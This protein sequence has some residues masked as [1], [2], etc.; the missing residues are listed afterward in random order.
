M[1]LDCKKDGIDHINIYSKARTAL[2]LFLSNF[3][4]VDLE[5]DY[6][7]FQS[8]EAFWYWLS[9]PEEHPRREELR[10]LAGWPA[11]KLGR[12]VRGIDYDADKDPAFQNQI[13]KVLIYKIDNS[14]FRREFALSTLPFQ[15]Y[16]V[17]SGK[18]SEP[19]SGK[20]QIEFFEEYRKQLKEEYGQMSTLSKG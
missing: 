2:G 16:Y 3:T 20:W 11:K 17:Y 18:V 6:G 10:T 7:S 5:T 1:E 9:A 13:K 8:V 12:E 15:H 4:H 14:S 19:Q